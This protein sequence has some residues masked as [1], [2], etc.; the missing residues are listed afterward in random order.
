MALDT[1]ALAADVRRLLGGVTVDEYAVAAMDAAI[2]AG[3]RAYARWQAK[4][5][6]ITLS[7]SA[8]VDRY[9]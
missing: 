2:L 5:T 1:A 7:V 8:G 3:L 6:D 4:T 9:A